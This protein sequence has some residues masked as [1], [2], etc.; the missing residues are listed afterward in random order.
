MMTSA[1]QRK[2][3]SAWA[4]KNREASIAWIDQ[5]ERRTGC[6]LCRSDHASCTFASGSLLCVTDGCRNPH[7]RH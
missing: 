5:K 6:P 2:A 4:K 1:A 3:R 7:C